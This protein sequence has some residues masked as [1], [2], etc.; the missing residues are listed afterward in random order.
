[1]TFEN[2]CF[3]L[4]NFHLLPILA[5][6]IIVLTGK[7]LLQVTNNKFSLQFTNS[8]S[9]FQ[10]KFYLGIQSKVLSNNADDEYDD[11]CDGNTETSGQ[12]SVSTDMCH[13]LCQCPKCQGLEKVQ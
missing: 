11:G 2:Q 12:S 7:F 5:P 13:P 4:E 10:V 9:L 6:F 3:G 8:F 1:M